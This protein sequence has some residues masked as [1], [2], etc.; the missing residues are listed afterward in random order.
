MSKILDQQQ[1]RRAFRDPD[2]D[3][4]EFGRAIRE[5]LK[6]SHQLRWLRQRRSRRPAPL[7]PIRSAGRSSHRRSGTGSK[8]LATS[9]KWLATCRK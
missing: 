4:S 7:G 5:M 1:I 3:F 9:S 6:R 8:R 2:Y